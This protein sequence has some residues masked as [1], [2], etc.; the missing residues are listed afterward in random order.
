ML[1][2]PKGRRIVLA[3]VAIV[4][5]AVAGWWLWENKLRP[6]YPVGPTVRI[7][8]WNLRQFSESRKGMDVSAIADVIRS[9]QF[10][11][12]AIQ[13]VKK[14]GEAVDRLLNILGSPWRAASLS[15]V[16]GNHER[17]AFIYNSDHVSEIGTPRFIATADAV[18][19]DRVPYQQ[20]FRAGN[21][22]FMLITVH[23]YYGEGRE[24]RERRRREVE[25]LARFVKKYASFA[26]EHDV[27]VLGD[28]NET[29][30]QENLRY[31]TSEG[32]ESLNVEPTNL[33][34]KEVYDNLL[35]DPKYTREWNGR[36]GAIRFDE[37]RFAN[38]DREAIQRI[39]DHR[40]VYADFV[41]SLPDDD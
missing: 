12:V 26:Q 18:I 6:R 24:G 28:L 27:I 32:W 19:F 22:D 4:L 20:S 16:T 13:E 15:D 1:A 5:L 40:P 7:A 11:L 37:T 3:V 41:T 23:L 30:G 25:T 17:F 31:F 14:D 29:R 10:D 35:I 33:G 8:T 2:T 9:N 39:S 38:D 21:F 36:A 34:S